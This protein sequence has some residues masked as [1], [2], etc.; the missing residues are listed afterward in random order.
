MNNY[1]KNS[2]RSSFS[3][4]QGNKRVGTFFHYT[5]I[6]KK[7]IFL[8]QINLSNSVG[9]G[10]QKLLHLIHLIFCH[11]KL[12]LRRYFLW[13]VKTLFLVN[14][15]GNSILKGSRSLTQTHG[16]ASE[17][18]IIAKPVVLYDGKHA[19]RWDQQFHDTCEGNCIQMINA[20]AKTY[21]FTD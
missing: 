15:V 9:I 2:Q 17:M 10:I 20:P 16:S 12:P 1:L 14:S 18:D 13:E 8:L 7:Y 21:V 5:I 11:S 4:A 19:E 6:E 3:N